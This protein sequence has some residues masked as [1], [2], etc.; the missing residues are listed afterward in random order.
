MTAPLRV[1]VL[2][3]WH[4]H[5]DDY[6]RAVREHPDTELVAAWDPDRG[7]GREGA[8]RLG[9]EFVAELGDLLARPDVDAVTVTTATNEHPAVIGAALAA[10][11]HVF[12]EKLLAATVADAEELV[13]LARGDGLAL[14]VSLP[15]LAAAHTLAARRL[16]DEGA[17]G[18]LTFVRFRMAHDGWLAGWL[19]ERFA[20]PDAAIGGA[21]ADLGCHPVYLVQHFLGARPETVAATYGSSTGRAVEDN[22]VVSMRYPHGAIGVAEASFVTVPGAFAFELRGTEGSLLYGYGR[23]VLVGKGA[24]LGDEWRELDVGEKG[25]APFD[26]WVRAIREDGDTSANTAAAIEL[27]RLVVA[28]NRSAA[29]GRAVVP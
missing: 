5:A 13:E 8:E 4:V 11:K 23:E 3:F 12:T 25:E 9:I 18:D 15:Q 27:T 29:S 14:V 21:L 17:L 19:P 20:D 2:G 16:I 22:A 1:A 24:L 28:A 26:Q 7:R 6:A 10:G